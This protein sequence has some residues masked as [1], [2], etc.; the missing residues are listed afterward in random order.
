MNDA[1]WERLADAVDIKFGITDHGS[2]TRPL[3]DRPDLSE[4]VEFI[5][6]AK[7]GDDFRLERITKPAIIDRKSIHGRS[8][9][10]GVRFE[11]IYHEK[12]TSTK[13]EFFRRTGNEW[14]PLNPEELSLE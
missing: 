9:H 4:K 8:A 5:E 2:L 7:G 10:A 11:N 13:V 12:E 1:S 3:E 6:F 14:Q